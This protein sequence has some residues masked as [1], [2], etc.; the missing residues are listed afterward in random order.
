MLFANFG[1]LALAGVHMLF[2]NRGGLA[3]IMCSDVPQA[4][5]LRAAWWEGRM[6]LGVG[7]EPWRGNHTPPSHPVEGCVE[8]RL[9]GCRGQ[10]LPA[11]ERR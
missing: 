5:T 2:A 11:G 7:I 10:E 1:G 9:G 6:L 8:V 4:V 3:N